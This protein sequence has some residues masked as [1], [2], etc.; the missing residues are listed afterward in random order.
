MAKNA[1][2]QALQDAVEQRHSKIH[3]FSD[4]WVQGALDRAVLGEWVKQHYHYVGHF[5]Q[6]CGNI[7]ANCGDETVSSFLVENI[8]EEEGF[9]EEHGFPAA[10][11]IDLLLD[12]GE[13]C[14][15][16]RQEIKDA[17]RNGELMAGTLGLQSWCAVQSTKPTHEAIA[18]LLVGLESQVPQI[19]KRTT[20]ALVEQYGF[21]EEEV[22]FFRLHIVA[23]TEHGRRG[24]EITEQLADT[25]EKQAACLRAVGE[26]TQMRRLYLDALYETYVA[27]KR[28]AAE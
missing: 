7:F 15:K 26:A 8:M 3:P 27:P 16:D 12:F 14:G 1:F 17:K 24:Y 21:T 28:A 4:A 2:R 25:E 5:S 11:H 19:Y 23:D 10:K 22:T 18:G 9:V 6:W 13:A 20:P